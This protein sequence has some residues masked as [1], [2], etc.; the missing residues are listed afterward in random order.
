MYGGVLLTLLLRVQLSI[1]GGHLFQETL[2]NT[3]QGNEG[4]SSSNNNKGI[5]SNVQEKYLALCQRFVQ[6]TIPLLCTKIH[7]LVLN[8]AQDLSLKN[9][10][11]I[12]QLE[13]SFRQY[14]EEV[15]NS[16]LFSK[17]SLLELTL[18][19]IFEAKLNLT[20]EHNNLSSQHY[21]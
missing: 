7:E 6:N 17:Q 13:A 12:A 11:S 15:E 2:N 18:G 10:F 8:S 4:P 3:Q 14:F 5:S 16:G 20:S 1:L 9:K 21:R 19:E